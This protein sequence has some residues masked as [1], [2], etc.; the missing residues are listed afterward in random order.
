MEYARLAAALLNEVAPPD[1]LVANA[2]NA[3][4]SAGLVANA[5]NE[6]RIGA[7]L[8]IRLP[9]DFQV[10]SQE[11]EQRSRALLIDW[12]SPAQLKQYALTR[13][14][15]FEVT[16]SGGRRYLITDSRT[17]GVFRLDADGREEERFCFVPAGTDNLATGDI[18]LAQKIALETDEEK[19]LA[20]AN[21]HWFALLIQPNEPTPAAG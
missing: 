11:A 1:G 13:G 15:S 10:R 18:M 3:L 4:Q 2:G 14:S 16:S 7:T 5:G 17:Y 21:R 20:V 12:L 8:R 19:A 6:P 9:Q